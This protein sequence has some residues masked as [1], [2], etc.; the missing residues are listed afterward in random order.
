VR[1]IGAAE[2]GVRPKKI[3]KA[4][5]YSLALFTAF[6][7]SANETDR[8]ALTK[9]DST[10][11]FRG[12][13][14]VHIEVVGEPTNDEYVSVLRLKKFNISINGKSIDKTGFEKLKDKVE[15]NLKTL[16]LSREFDSETPNDKRTIYILEIDSGAEAYADI[17]PAT[18]E[19]R[20]RLII[21]FE[22]SGIISAS[23]ISKVNKKLYPP[24]KAEQDA[25]AN[26]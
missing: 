16:E 20:K 10:F 25:A 7:C 22:A 9:L 6:I 19:S 15:V 8:S 12:G 24:D 5:F 4:L 26:P 3:M 1:P 2:L 11:S 23:E 13:D 18:W 14:T 17:A 21:E